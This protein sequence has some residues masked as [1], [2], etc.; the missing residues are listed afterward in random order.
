MKDISPEDIR[1]LIGIATGEIDKKDIPHALNW[2]NKADRMKLSRY[3]KKLQN[4]QN[5][6]LY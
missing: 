6:Q 3:M 1:I 2:E 5:E 4:I